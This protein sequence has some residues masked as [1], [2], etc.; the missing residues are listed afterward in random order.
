M[1]GN[2]NSE[3][4]IEQSPLPNDNI[5]I[6]MNDINE[7]EDDISENFTGQ[8]TAWPDRASDSLP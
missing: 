5:V 8:L 4:D 2:I 6:E 1:M 7:I 3:E